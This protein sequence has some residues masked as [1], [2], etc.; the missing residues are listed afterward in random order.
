MTPKQQEA[1]IKV[2]NN[3]DVLK[4]LRREFDRSFVISIAEETGGKVNPKSPPLA[5]SL[6]IYNAADF[7][8]IR[9]G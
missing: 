5:F 4:T 3:P 8:G 7:K 1:L 2:L 6:N 9:V